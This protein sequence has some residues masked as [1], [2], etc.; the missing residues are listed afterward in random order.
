MIHSLNLKTTPKTVLGSLDFVKA[1]KVGLASASFPRMREFWQADAYLAAVE[2][3]FVYA[4]E[5]EDCPVTTMATSVHE[6]LLWATGKFGN[7]SLCPDW[8]SDVFGEQPS[9][10][11]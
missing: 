3:A 8:I 4:G 10:L 1:V 5:L 7:H 9:W 6:Y 2:L 11:L